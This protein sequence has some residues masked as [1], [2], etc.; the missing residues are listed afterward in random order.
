MT[1]S[2]SNQSN[3][4][5][6]PADTGRAKK[7]AA[8][9]DNVHRISPRNRVSSHNA[10]STFAQSEQ[11]GH[12]HHN[13]AIMPQSSH[14]QS[15]PSNK[16]HR[17]HLSPA[18]WLDMVSFDAAQE[19]DFDGSALALPTTSYADRER[20]PSIPVILQ[21]HLFLSPSST[22]YNLETSPSS[23]LPSTRSGRRNDQESKGMQPLNQLRRTRVAIDPAAALNGN[24]PSA[25]RS[26]NR[27]A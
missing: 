13:Q 27:I 15:Y 6:G 25:S 10:V 23:H 8:G 20:V 17:I 5:Q 11:S 4:A 26:T 18:P 19:L 9:Q 24:L 7:G 1:A 21:K 22:T 14:Q 16:N 12:Q 2:A 3:D